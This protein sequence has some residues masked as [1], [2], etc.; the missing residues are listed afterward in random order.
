MT[1]FT[2]IYVCVL[3]SPTHQF[4]LAT[5]HVLRSP[6][7][8]V[9]SLLDTIALD[10][11]SRCKDVCLRVTRIKIISEVVN[12]RELFL[13]GEGWGVEGVGKE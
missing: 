3:H 4:E 2:I 1:Y 5:F 13:G 9:N 7:W 11:Q 12:E 10:L 6:Q 8:L